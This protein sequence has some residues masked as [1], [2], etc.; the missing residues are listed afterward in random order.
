MKKFVLVLSVFVLSSVFAE[1]VKLTEFGDFIHF[2]YRNE[3]SF[4]KKDAI[5]KVD[6]SK[7]SNKYR[8]QL[9]TVL[10]EGNRARSSESEEIG[11]F[12]K[13][14]SEALVFIKQ[15]LRLCSKQ[16]LNETGLDDLFKTEE[17]KVKKP[18]VGSGSSIIK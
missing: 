11:F 1:P 5:K 12:F 6:F 15:I 3:D 10:S 18:I 13:E 2:V 9:V 17:K 8:V 16:S 4:L 14:K 7:F